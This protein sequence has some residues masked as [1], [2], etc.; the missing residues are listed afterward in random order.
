MFKKFAF[1]ILTICSIANTSNTSDI[2]FNEICIAVDGH[3]V[4]LER[5][6]WLAI[7][8][9]WQSKD[10]L[11]L[12]KRFAEYGL[13]RLRAKN[14][15]DPRFCIEKF[16]EN[17][18]G[19]L[20]DKALDIVNTFKP[21]QKVVTELERLKGLGIQL[22]LFSNIGPRM[23][24]DMQTK[25]PELSQLFTISVIPT[26]ENNYITKRSAKAAKTLKEKCSDC[27]QLIMLDDSRKKIK[28]AE[29]VNGNPKIQGWLY[30]NA[31]QFIRESR[32]RFPATIS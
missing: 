20:P 13:F 16:L 31:A 24:N 7:K 19:S 30:K 17:K 11:I 12:L 22:A 23:L 25:H 28:I 32:E 3:D 21:N 9:F 2:K 15:E 10:K 27:K 18:D 1:A 8:A 29:S 14:P 4:A 26:L 5:D 6:Y